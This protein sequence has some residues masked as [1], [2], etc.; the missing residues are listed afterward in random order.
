MIRL[1]LEER[2]LEIE[3]GPEKSEPI[4]KITWG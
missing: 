1:G 3:I 4:S 2:L